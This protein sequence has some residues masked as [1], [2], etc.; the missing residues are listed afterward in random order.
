[1][2][3][4]YGKV[5]QFLNETCSS[6]PTDRMYRASDRTWWERSRSGNGTLGYEWVKSTAPDD[7]FSDS[8]IVSTRIGKILGDFTIGQL[9]DAVSAYNNKMNEKIV[10]RMMSRMSRVRKNVY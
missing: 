6:S 5:H 3:E 4:D 10:E 9:M 8:R 2:S 7:L 1:M